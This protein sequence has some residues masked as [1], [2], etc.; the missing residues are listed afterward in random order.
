MELP[1]RQPTFSWKPERSWSPRIGRCDDGGQPAYDLSRRV[2]SPR[3]RM[4]GARQDR[5]EC[6]R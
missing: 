5:W 1:V 4:L 3:S 6:R 2:S